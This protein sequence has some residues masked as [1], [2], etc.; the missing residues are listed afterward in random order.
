VLAIR[1]PDPAG[2][3][4]DSLIANPGGDVRLAPGQLLVVM[5]S[6]AQLQRFG[7]LLGSGLASVESMPA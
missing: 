1:N 7:A 3:G 4:T 6:Q 2:A 5:G